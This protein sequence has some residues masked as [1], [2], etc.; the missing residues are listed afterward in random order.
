MARLRIYPSVSVDFRKLLK[1]HVEAARDPSRSSDMR[2]F[3]KHQ[4]KIISRKLASRKPFTRRDLREVFNWK[5]FIA[6]AAEE[7]SNSWHQ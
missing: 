7:I 4:A 1:F 5:K 3:H 6:L 2:D